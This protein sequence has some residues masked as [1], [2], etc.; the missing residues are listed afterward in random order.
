MRGRGFIVWMGRRI[1]R[2]R[3]NLSLVFL[4]FAQSKFAPHMIPPHVFFPH[5]SHTHAFCP[6]LMTPIAVS[7]PHCFAP[8]F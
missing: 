8:H 1:R 4:H 3:S 5:S 6:Y 7:D 2:R